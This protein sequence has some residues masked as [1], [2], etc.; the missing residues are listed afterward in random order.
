MPAGKVHIRY[1]KKF[2]PITI[3]IGILIC[4]VDFIGGI[5]FITGY[6]MGYFI[7]PDLDQVSVTSAEGRLLRTFGCFGAVMVGYWFPYGHLMKH[8]SF[9]SH[10]PG[11]STAMRIAYGFW[12]IVPILY[13]YSLINNNLLLIVLWIWVGLSLADTIHYILDGVM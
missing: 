7:D 10:F 4:L 12:W 9:W 2:L 5:F 11:I 8:R 1:W 6:V 13:H 3:F